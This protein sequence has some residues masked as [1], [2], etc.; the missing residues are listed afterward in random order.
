MGW[1][2]GSTLIED[3]IRALATR[4]PDAACRKAIYVDVIRAFQDH[5]WDC[6]D[7]C[8]GLDP[9]FDEALRELRSEDGD[10]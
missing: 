10:D 2:S 9:A 4:V 5:D 7:E 1:S 6:E 3:I 8:T